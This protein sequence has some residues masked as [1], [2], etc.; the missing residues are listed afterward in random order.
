M[1]EYKRQ[2]PALTYHHLHQLPILWSA[3][4]EGNSTPSLVRKY[5]DG[6]ADC[7]PGIS[8]CYIVGQRPDEDSIHENTYEP[9]LGEASVSACSAV[10]A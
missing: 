1:Q 7:L 4:A 3:Y 5:H 8:I 9:G 2:G 10:A 6:L